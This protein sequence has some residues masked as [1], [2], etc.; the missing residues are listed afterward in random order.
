[1]TEGVPEAAVLVTGGTGFVGTALVRQ[2]LALGRE[3][4]VLAR[5]GSDRSGL[6]ELGPHWLDGDLLEPASLERAVARFAARAADLGRPA[7]VVHSAAL[8]SYLTRDAELARRVNVEGT[9]ALVEACVR[10]RIERLCQV[11]SIVTVGHAA[12]ARSS[13]DEDAPFTGG[14]LGSHYVTTKRAAE[15]LALAAARELEVVVVNPGAIFGR[16]PALSNTT[17]FLQR[18]SRGRVPPFAPPGSLS[19]VGV[20]DVAEGIRL[21]LEKGRRARRY[22][23]TESILSLHELLSLAASE[24]GARPPRRTLPPE[25]WRLVVTGS[26]WVD[27]VR[28]LQLTTPQSLRLLGVHYRCES[29]RAR[30][31]LGWSPRPFREVL[32]DT[33]AWMR[34]QGLVS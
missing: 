34:E 30:A 9:R 22:L 19:V 3:V 4:H 13:L 21:A 10:H 20:E 28:P 12:D 32:A 24:L 5:A 2:L 17:R 16:F 33:V 11:S 26:R 8:I 31:E 1:M 7:H 14:E 29:R 23:L 6:A 15:E 25:L 27:R 18:L